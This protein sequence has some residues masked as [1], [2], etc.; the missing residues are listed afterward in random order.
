MQRIS[1][2]V[3]PH[4]IQARHLQRA[5]LAHVDVV[6]LLLAAVLQRR[7][8]DVVGVGYKSLQDML[9]T[10][11]IR[12][13]MLGRE[14][15]RIRKFQMGCNASTTFLKGMFRRITHAS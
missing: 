13:Y 11:R 4:V 8:S 15:V 7:P 6:R 5:L 12:L 2:F 9:Y 1:I 10:G 3:V 14:L